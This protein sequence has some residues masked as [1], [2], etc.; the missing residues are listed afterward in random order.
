MPKGS[1][2]A[3]SGG[4]GSGAADAA[5][6]EVVDQATLPDLPDASPDQ[7]TLD[8]HI[9]EVLGLPTAE[10]GD[11]KGKGDDTTKSDGDNGKG[12]DDKADSGDAGD[13]NVDKGESGEQQ[14]DDGKG[15]AVTEPAPKTTDKIDKESDRTPTESGL[16][17]E[18]TDKNG[19]TFTLKPGDDID[20]VL[21]EFDPKNTAQV[22]SVLRQFDQMEQKQTAWDAEQAENRATAEQAKTNQATLSAWDAE[23]TSLQGEDR[24]GKP[25]AKPGTPE[26]VNDPAVKRVDQVFKFMMAENA[27]RAEAK[28]P[29]LIT[30]FADALDK[31]ELQEIRTKQ[32]QDKKDE[33]ETAKQKSALIGGRPSG[34]GNAA[35]VY[36]P[37]QAKSVWDIEI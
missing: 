23:I 27:R 10:A 25:A 19:K 2:A 35:P 37:G 32:A 22:M 20:T 12:G 9:D 13:G 6:S 15:E 11:D 1:A 17:L 31:L 21:A 7:A 16:K 26:F 33:V 18:I 5:A 14:A 3:S 36:R 28:N 4:D 8:S 30:S 34:G 29:N 24:I